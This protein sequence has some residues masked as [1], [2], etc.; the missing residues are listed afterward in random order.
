[1]KTA[2]LAVLAMAAALGV[3]CGGGTDSETPAA[4][5]S[6]NVVIDA[7]P[8]AVARVEVSGGGKSAGL[9]RMGPR[10]RPEG[11]T[12]AT[13]ATALLAAEDD[14]LPLQAYR[15][16]SADELDPLFGLAHPT[17]VLRVQG[18]GGRAWSLE[19]GGATPTGGGF[20]AR[21]PGSNEIYL[22]ARATFLSLLALLPDGARLA[23]L[24]PPH[25]EGD[26]TPPLEERRE[27]NPW[28]RQA[29]AASTQESEP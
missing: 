1:M 27:T 6:D 10:W 29:Q 28:L 22:L 24:S 25:H 12:P 17:L 23:P 9:V 20:Y 5:P 2:T 18:D 16:F 19:V 14:L 4:I 26:R 13:A 21:R 7:E 8:A 15:K 3:A 11:A